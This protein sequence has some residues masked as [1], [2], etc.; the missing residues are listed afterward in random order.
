ME[1]MERG[2]GQRPE[3]AK[4]GRGEEERVVAVSVGGACLVCNP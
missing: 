3:E 2:A 1:K 4:R